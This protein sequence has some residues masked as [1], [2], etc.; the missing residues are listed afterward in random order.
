[1][2]KRGKRRKGTPVRDVDKWPDLSEAYAK[3]EHLSPEEKLKVLEGM[4]TEELQA[5]RGWMNSLIRE[6]I[7][8]NDPYDMLDEFRT[9]LKRIDDVLKSRKG[10]NGKP[11]IQINAK[12]GQLKGRG[13][14]L[15]SKK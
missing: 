4:V 2:S 14:A 7:K 1:M 11:A 9:N 5:R 15:S 8:C 3:R 6:A 10:K 13:V 12:T